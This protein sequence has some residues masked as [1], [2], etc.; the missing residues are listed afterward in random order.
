MIFFLKRMLFKKLLLKISDNYQENTSA[1]T[2]FL[3]K[4]KLKL[5]A[6]VVYKV[7]GPTK[8][9]NKKN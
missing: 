5:H 8:N 9:E 4:D 6:A 2:L 3:N 7:G 1:G